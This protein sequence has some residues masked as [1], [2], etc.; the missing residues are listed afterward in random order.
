MT[1]QSYQILVVI[2]LACWLS[3]CDSQPDGSPQRVSS[4]AIE[5]SGENF[6]QAVYEVKAVEEFDPQDSPPRITY[7][8]NRWI[9]TQ[10]PK[11]S[12]KLDP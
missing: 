1:K 2:T 12:W 8:L 6:A 4:A 7:H 9:A 5:N 11:E 10:D 3:G